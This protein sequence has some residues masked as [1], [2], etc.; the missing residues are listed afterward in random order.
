[1]RG[2]VFSGPSLPRAAVEA[3]PGLEWR[4][5][6]RQGDLYRAALERP[7][8]I[9][10]VDGYFE[11]VPATWHKE[12]LWALAEGI[13]VYG[14]ASIG[15]LRAAELADFGM[16]GVGRIYDDFHSGVLQDDDEVALLHGPE[17]A[18]F[19]AVSEAMVNV[20]ATVAAART[21]AIIDA[22]PAEAVTRAAKCLF[23]KQRSYDAILQA[24]AVL[25]PDAQALEHFRTWAPMHR[26]DQKRRDATAMI[27]RMHADRIAGPGR[28]APS[29][30]FAC[31]AYWRRFASYTKRPW[32]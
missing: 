28:A 16:I 9:G 17:E 8:A 2:I 3:V 4:P 31:T 30:H 24:A 5:P 1:M 27:D 22:Q 25:L 18:G 26:V 23:Y 10:V 21:A 12:I 29:F 13:R 11:V 32:G 14:S 19:V 20:R 15:A 7:D 6:L